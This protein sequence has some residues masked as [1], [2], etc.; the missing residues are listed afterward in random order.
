MHQSCEDG[1]SA[2]VCGLKCTRSAVFGATAHSVHVIK[3][4]VVVAEREGRVGKWGNE[5]LGVEWGR[6][7][8]AN[9]SEREREREN[10]NSELQNFILQGV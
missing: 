8:C 9:S 6:G 4:V 7:E 10:S 3:W 1:G 5:R 2:C